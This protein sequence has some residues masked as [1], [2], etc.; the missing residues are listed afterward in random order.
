MHG[1]L[2][3]KMKSCSSSERVQAGVGHQGRGYQVPTACG[4]DEERELEIDSLYWHWGYCSIGGVGYGLVV[5][6]RSGS[7]VSE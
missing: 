5:G 2:A 1:G 3:N 4:P 6:S 7:L